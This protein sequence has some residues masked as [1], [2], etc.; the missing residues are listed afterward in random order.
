MRVDAH[1]FLEF[2]SVR[3]MR[4]HYR[5]LAARMKALRSPPEPPAPPPPPKP[6][7]RVVEPEPEPPPPPA[8]KPTPLPE[9][10]QRGRF[11][12]EII[13]TCADYYGLTPQQVCGLSRKLDLVTARHIASMFIE[14]LCA[15]SLPQIARA[16]GRLDH[17][18]IVH[19]LRRVQVRMADPKFVRTVGSI[20]QKLES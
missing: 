19:A 2:D 4:A 12:R 17:T 16:V 1:G 11:I 14:D 5:R 6:V 15:V 7:V 18:S 20:R 9:P 10:I 8:P 3:E 13:E